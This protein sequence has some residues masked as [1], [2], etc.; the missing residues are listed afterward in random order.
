MIKKTHL[1]I[2]LA[3][4]LY[5]LP[6][7]T[8]KALFLPIILIA[9][10][11]PDIDSVNSSLGKYRI[12]R[13]I[14]SFFEHRGPLHSYTVLIILSLLL[15]FF[16]PI[17]SLPFFLGY[18]IHLFADSFTVRGIKPFWPFKYHTAGVIK[19]GGVVDKALFYTFVIIDLF[20]FILLFYR[21]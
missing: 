1:A 10:L 3:L 20:L 6:F 17:Y 16:Y 15:A 14:Q 18:S 13:P 5:F 8:H 19:S 9:S 11:L 7:M 12:F 4:G 2:G 21:F